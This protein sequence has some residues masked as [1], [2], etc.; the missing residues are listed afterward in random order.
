MNQM[1]DFG[2]MNKLYWTE[3]Y[4]EG[5]ADHLTRLQLG[6]DGISFTEKKKG[7]EHPWYD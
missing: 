1:A 6:Y 7:E 4:M 5:N 3:F 2:E